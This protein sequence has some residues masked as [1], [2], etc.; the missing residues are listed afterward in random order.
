MA[1]LTEHRRTTWNVLVEAARRFPSNEALVF[2]DVEGRV[3]RE[4]YSSLHAKARTLAG[5]LAR[6]GVGRGHR[7]AILMTNRVE[8]VLTFFAVQSLGAVLVPINTRLTRGEVQQILDASRPQHVIVL[9]RFR[10]L[11]FLAMLAEIHPWRQEPSNDSVTDLPPAWATSIVVCT[12]DGSDPPLATY[13]FAKLCKGDRRTA[14]MS[15][16]HAVRRRRP[17]GRATDPALIKFTSGS[18]GPPKGVVLKQGGLVTSGR[19][20]V[21]RLGLSSHDRFFNAR[22]MFHSGGSIFGIMTV[23]SC[24]ATLVFPEVWDVEVALTMLANERCTVNFGVTTMNFDMINAIRSTPWHCPTLRMASIGNSSGDGGAGMEIK[25]ALGVESVFRVY[26][27]TEAYGPVSMGSPK[28]QALQQTHTHGRPLSG[29]EVRVVD[30][31]TGDPVRNGEIGHGLVRGLVMDGYLDEPTQTAAAVDSD[32]WL[33]TGD[34]LRIDDEG[35][36]TFMGRLKSMLKVAGENVSIE[37]VENCIRQYEG[38][39]ECCVIGVPDERRNEVGRAFITIEPN[40]EISE[41]ELRAWLLERLAPFKVPRDLVVVESLPT[42]ASGKV[43]RRAL[44]SSAWL[45]PTKTEAM[46]SSPTMTTQKE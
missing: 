38:V 19:L 23:V 12:R 17:V 44:A 42:T 21:E 26:G 45:L 8:Y 15:A 43:D 35:F 37:E 41:Q 13:D 28:D 2:Q 5:S 39:V 27:L 32:G 6:I 3:Q 18:T 14:M 36:I 9:D 33:H 16:R 25:D 24:G 30:P 1:D 34:L 10:K 20:Q 46:A 4:T 29:V 31:R 40:V 7:L 11:D 22:P